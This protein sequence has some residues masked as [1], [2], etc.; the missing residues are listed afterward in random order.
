MNE[1]LSLS[2]YIYICIFIYIYIYKYI[3]IYIYTYT[4]IPFMFPRLALNGCPCAH[5][6]DHP[7]LR[8]EVCC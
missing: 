8:A 1:Y 6:Q 5:N 4:Y 7:H 2:I 3:Y